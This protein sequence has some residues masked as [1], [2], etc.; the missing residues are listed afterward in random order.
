MIMITRT[1]TV[2]NDD[3]TNNSNNITPYGF[4]TKLN[5]CFALSLPNDLRSRGTLCS[6]R[7][8]TN[9]TAVVPVA[10]A[11]VAI[12]AVVAVAVVAVV[13]AV[14]V[15]AVVAVA[16]VAVVAVVS[17]ACYRILQNTTEYFRIPTTKNNNT[18]NNTTANN[19][20]NVSESQSNQKL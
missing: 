5:A 13:V 9:F 8:L 2:V 14:A 11:V 19:H 16:V 1:I 15:V 7:S 10:V 6:T 18:N 20:D 12:V 17:V 3:K 4:A